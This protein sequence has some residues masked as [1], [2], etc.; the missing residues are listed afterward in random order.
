MK[1]KLKDYVLLG[2]L[3]A[4]IVFVKY[5]PKHELAIKENVQVVELSSE[6]KYNNWVISQFERDGSN[7]QLINYVKNNLNNPKSFK[8]VKTI[9]G[10]VDNDF[11]VKMTYRATN[12]FNAII[13]K[14]ILVGIN[15][16]TNEMEIIEQ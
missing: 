5:A 1:I 11:R 13:T 9:Y 3:I 6:Q 7:M 15:Y 12:S 2:I 10:K 4:M 8:H 14:T 16:D